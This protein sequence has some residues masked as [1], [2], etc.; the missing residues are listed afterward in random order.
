MSNFSLFFTISLLVRV[1]KPNHFKSSP[2]VR[3][4][5]SLHETGHLGRPLAA[6]GMIINDHHLID[7]V[8][9]PAHHVT[10]SSLIC[11]TSATNP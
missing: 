6:F 11:F 9:N 2:S 8:S 7:T 5:T 3:L 4:I 10:Q 1:S